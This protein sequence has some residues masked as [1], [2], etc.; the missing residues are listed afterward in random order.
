[1]KGFIMDIIKASRRMAI[2]AVLLFSSQAA[3]GPALSQEW[4]DTAVTENLV[5]WFFTSTV[6][7]EYTKY[8]VLHTG[9][10]MNFMALAVYE[11]PAVQ[12]TDGTPVINRLLEQIRFMVAGGNE[13]LCRGTIAGWADNSAAQTLALARH[14]PVVWDALTADEKTRCDWLMKSLTVAGNYCQNFDATVHRDLFQ[15]YNWRKEWNPNHQEGY[16]GV[17][18]AAWF[19]FGGTDA[20]NAMLA[21]FDYDQWTTAL[22]S[23]GLT[24]ITGCWAATGKARMENGGLDDGSGTIVSVRTPF[25]YKNVWGAG[26]QVEYQP[27]PVFKV[28]ADRMYKHMCSDTVKG[29]S[30]TLN[31]NTPWA[32][33]FG[34]GFEFI[35][36]DASGVRSDARYVYDGWCNS[37]LTTATMIALN[38]FGSGDAHNDVATRMV[39]GSE[40]LIY[41]LAAG[42]QGRSKGQETYADSS[43]VAG[44]GYFYVQDIWL[45]VI[46]P[47]FAATTTAFDTTWTFIR[48][49]SGFA[50]LNSDFV[51]RTYNFATS[52]RSSQS[53][54]P[55]EV[56]GGTMTVTFG[57]DTAIN[58]LL[59][60]FI[61]DETYD[62]T[63]SL[64]TGA[65][66]VDVIHESGFAASAGRP[67]LF[68]FD[69]IEGVTAIRL[70][71]TEKWLFVSEFLGIY[72]EPPL[73]VG[74]MGHRR[75]NRPV[76]SVVAAGSPRLYDAA[77]RAIPLN[78]LA[79]VP[80]Q[81]ATTILPSSGA[82]AAAGVYFSQS[83]KIMNPQKK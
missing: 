82:T 30:Y 1:M 10:A 77:G 64:Q 27:F 81:H 12:T 44:L 62:F 53:W 33:R 55:G 21:G 72:Y 45:N 6:N 41:K 71:T 11:D 67:A 80:R 8:K 7:Q 51:A 48:P 63:V 15:A 52:P 83:K 60:D 61:N 47:Y 54:Y 40:D 4:I 5:R 32:G 65:G 50:D 22:D 70:T 58:A 34:M 74:A 31:G 13:P 78:M 2:G 28:L 19:Y 68:F 73:A 69:E 66:W 57:Q 14:T 3:A 76:R 79:R 20:V 29:D 24:N 43:K 39:V 9:K 36:G 75:P 17:M 38:G 49:D 23:M 25:T 26:E 59:I 18:I 46:K 56:G 42:Y 35:A 37:I 16:V